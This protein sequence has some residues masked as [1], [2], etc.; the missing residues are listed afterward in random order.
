MSR[1]SILYFEYKEKS[2][3]EWKLFA[4][5]VKKNDLYL[6]YHYLLKEPVVINNEEYVHSFQ[7]EIQGTIRDYLNDNYREF[8]CRGFPK[9]MSPE[10]T[11]Y[12]ERQKKNECLDGTWGH[13]WVDIDELINV[14]KDDYNRNKESIC[15][16][17]SKSEFEKLHDKLDII[18]KTIKKETIPIST[19]KKDDEDSYYDRL[20]YINELTEENEC[21]DYAREYLEGV[22]LMIAILNN[23][24]ADTYDIRIVYF[25]C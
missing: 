5:L 15:S 1:T 21:L 24:W 9:D 16:Y 2:A 4:P 6:D 25:T 12:I 23:A 18:L 14:I 20:E 13:S 8:N 22:K 10:L 11:E 3:W 17:T 19:T 7:D